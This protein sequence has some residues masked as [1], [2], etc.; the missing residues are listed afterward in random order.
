[1]HDKPWTLLEQLQK[2]IDFY[3]QQFG[4]NLAAE[5]FKAT[6]RVNLPDEKY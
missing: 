1:M 2:L 5:I 6:V 3:R 4:N